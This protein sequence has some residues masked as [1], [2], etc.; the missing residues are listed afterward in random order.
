MKILI[1]Y[2]GSECSDAALED[3][4]R[5][6]LP[7]K[8]DVLIL[9]VTDVWLP[10][11]NGN[12]T[13]G[14]GEHISKIVKAARAFVQKAVKK[15][16]SNFPHWKVQTDTPVGSPASMIIQK[17]KEWNADLIVIGSHGRSALGRMRWGS[18]SQSVAT[19]AHCSV[20]ISRGRRKSGVQD[21]K[22]IVGIDGSLHSKITLK[23]V[24]S[25]IWPD[26]SEI[27]V[28]AVFDPS[29]STGVVIDR[30]AEY[31]YQWLTKI[32]NSA[33]KQLKEAGLH[34]TG[35][36]RG[37][38]PKQ[39]L[40]RKAKKWGADCVFVGAKGLS[41]IKHLLFGSV[42]TAVAMRAHCSV[43]IVRS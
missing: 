23:S 38:D 8:A 10:E 35:L 1:A 32:V 7:R 22:I 33:E 20:R 17:A 5:A 26:E 4:T 30:D 43:E 15:I 36:V 28:L 41:P 9:S 24:A 11:A 3:L 12:I 39:V 21:V 13:R 42:A 29:L 16:R 34:A 31:R 27:R 6:G 14:Q 40:V 37:G 2:D 19:H 25:R 18:V